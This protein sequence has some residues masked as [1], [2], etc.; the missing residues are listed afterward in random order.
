MSGMIMI[1][2]VTFC[3]PPI[4]VTESITSQKQKHIAKASPSGS[5]YAYTWEVK[6]NDA[7]PFS[8]VHNAFVRLYIMS[9]PWPKKAPDVIIVTKAMIK[10]VIDC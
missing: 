8:H 9:Y 2:I 1:S 5:I 7:D 10:L 4:L 6:A 3:T